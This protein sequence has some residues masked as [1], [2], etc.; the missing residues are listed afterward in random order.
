MTSRV[1]GYPGT[2][3][4][5]SNERHTVCI[6]RSTGRVRP[7]SPRGYLEPAGNDVTGTRDTRSFCGTPVHYS[8]I[9]SLGTRSK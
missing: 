5:D 6:D 4:P 1:S 2:H 3:E 8:S 9:I 7:K